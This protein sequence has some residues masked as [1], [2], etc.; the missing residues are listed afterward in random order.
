MLHLPQ[1]P[2]WPS[3]FVRLEWIADQ[4]YARLMLYDTDSK[5]RRHPHVRVP[6]TKRQLVTADDIDGIFEPS[7]LHGKLYTS[8]LYQFD[9]RSQDQIRR[10]LGTF[11]TNENIEWRGRQIGPLLDRHKPEPNEWLSHRRA[12]WH[13]NT[14]H[15]D[16]VLKDA[17]RYHAIPHS[18]WEEHQVA[19]A[20]ITASLHLC[21][22]EMKLSFTPPDEIAEDIGVTVP[23]E[24]GKERFDKQRLVPDYLM[25][26]DRYYAIET[27]MGTET[28]RASVDLTHRKKTYQR[29][30]LQY[31]ELIGR[32]L[33]DGSRLYNR[34]YKIPRDKPLMVLFVTTEKSKLAL[35]KDII[36]EATDRKGCNWFL[37]QHLHSELIDP[38]MS[39]E[40]LVS[41]WIEPWERAGRPPFYICNPG[42]Q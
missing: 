10:R 7:N 36:M 40:P 9:G 35:M 39:P 27:D 37:M 22:R 4:R 33:P 17:G 15:A 18:G 26:L 1:R 8:Y 3:P 12:Q 31:R 16:R 41:L 32:Q 30:F 20:C 19:N 14:P 38:F 42:R 5:G 13:Q 34:V 25:G 28:G 29:M 6:S 11:F 2:C 21:A 24:I 23:Y